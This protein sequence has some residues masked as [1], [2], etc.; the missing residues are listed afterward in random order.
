MRYALG[1]LG[2]APVAMAW[3]R[4][5]DP[6][7]WSIWAPQ[8]RSVTW[9]GGGAMQIIARD[10]ESGILIGGTDA[11]VEGAVLGR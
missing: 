6:G 2:P 7:L 10:P 11:R 4:Y 1:V 3:E 8:I 5:A 9:A